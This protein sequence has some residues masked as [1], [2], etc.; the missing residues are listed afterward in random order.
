K[1]EEEEEDGFIFQIHN[2]DK[3]GKWDYSEANFQCKRNGKRDCK[4]GKPDKNPLSQN[5]PSKLRI[6]HCHCFHQKKDKNWVSLPC[7]F[8]KLDTAA[9]S[10]RL[11]GAAS[12]L[13]FPPRD[14]GGFCL[15]FP[16]SVHC[17]PA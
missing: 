7:G 1:E 11:A 2:F 4:L 9:Y 6:H 12:T 5:P 15:A 13:L 17:F 10:P 16:G 14:V 3:A 8:R